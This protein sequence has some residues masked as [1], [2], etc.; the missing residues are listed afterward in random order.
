MLVR[1]RGNWFRPYNVRMW[2]PSDDL[3]PKE[4]FLNV[5]EHKKNPAEFESVKP[6]KPVGEHEDLVPSASKHLGWGLKSYT[7]YNLISSSAYPT[8]PNLAAGEILVGS[9]LERNTT[10]NTPGQSSLEAIAGF[11][12]DNFR[13]VGYAEN[14]NVPDSSNVTGYMDFRH[15]RLPIGHADRRPFYYF[16]T[17]LFATF[18]GVLVRGTVVKMVHLLW[19]NR[20]VVAAGIVDVDL[21]NIQSGDNVVVKF[22]GKPVFVRRRTDEMIRL[23]EK[24]DSVVS[25]MR[26][27]EKD[28]E[29]VKRKEWLVTLGV[30]THLGCIPFPNEGMYGGYFCPCHGSHYDHS[31]R[32]RFGPAPFNM[33]IPDYMFVDD[34]TIRLGIK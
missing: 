7:P 20:G 27:P 34:N 10:W 28:V 4:S 14:A 18:A 24:D 32:I 23:A 16:T 15:N 1:T 22:R 19:P 11:S 25:T 3:V 12:P 30:C 21:S 6:L 33:E 17:A 13:P 31:G 5:F 26:D 2:S 29:R 9:K 8:E